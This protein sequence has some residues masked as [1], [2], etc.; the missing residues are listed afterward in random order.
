MR[1][2][3][4]VVVVRRGTQLLVLERSQARGGYW[5]LVAGGVEDG[6]SA[7]EAAARELE[8]ETGLRAS[9]RPLGLDLQYEGPSGPVRVDSFVADA[10]PA[11]EP[12]LDDEHVAYR[13]CDLD[14]AV[15]LLAYEEP[16]VAVRA[17]VAA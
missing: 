16:R 14:E 7:T 13:W 15:G 5:N 17:A 4:V 6:E 3:E 1:R 9:V 10:T 12:A 8:E 2:H 11:W